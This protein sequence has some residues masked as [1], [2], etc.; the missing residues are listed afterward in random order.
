MKVEVRSV[1]GGSKIDPKKVAVYVRWSTDE[2]ESGT[3]LEVQTESCQYFIKSQGWEFDPKL[4]Y[5][6][7]GYSGGNTERPAL[8]KLRK[9]IEAG[10]IEAVVVYKLDRLSRRVV[11]CVKLVRE[12][13]YGRCS[14]FSTAERFDT[15]SPVGKMIFNI[16]ISFAEFERDVIRDRTQSGKKKRA[17]QGR[18]AGHKYM[19]GYRRGEDGSYQLDGYD[20]ANGAFSGAAAVAR[21]IFT[22]YLSGVSTVHIAEQLT[23]EGIPSPLG[24]PNWRPSTVA[25]ILDN[26]SYAGT[27]RYGMSQARIGEKRKQLDGPTYEVEGAIPPLVSFEEFERVSRLREDRAT[28]NPRQLGSSYL[29]SGLAKCGKCGQP[30]NGKQ[31][32]D[33]RYYSCLG[34]L[35]LKNCDCALM[36]AEVLEKTVLE[37]VKQRFSGE[38]MREHIRMI[39]DKIRTTIAARQHAVS[40]S[41][42]ELGVLEKR[43]EKLEADYFRGDL[44]GKTYGR[45]LERV[46]AE[47]SRVEGQL[48][49]SRRALKESESATVNI[50]HLLE[51]SSRIDIW[52]TLAPGTVKQVL[53]DVVDV[54]FIYQEKSSAPKGKRNPNE[55][56]LRIAFR[57][58][59]LVNTRAS[60]EAR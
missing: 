40:E 4:V 58:D 52:E 8:T 59:V 50:A 7:D 13:W 29:L 16:L 41:Q 24:A 31:G 60:G 46:E 53:Q 1:F 14:L 55:I 54:V 26:P 12:E 21:R 6:D 37:Q 25:R 17:S 27:Y 2:Q 11:D 18:N 15:E 32:S 51:L 33:K 34:R 44:D 5:V 22:D 30:I 36:G 38:S 57:T 35:I 48:D 45:L 47:K 42:V 23:Q 49:T 9:S 39:E 19:Y 10:E 43:L 28:M 56:D 20:P 3:T